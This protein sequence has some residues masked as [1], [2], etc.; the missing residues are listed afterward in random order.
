MSK[1]KSS[2]SDKVTSTPDGLKIWHQERVIFEVTERLC[3]LMEE[4]G[5][6][7]TELADLLGKTKGYITQILGGNANLTLRSLSDIYLALGHQFKVDDEPL[8]AEN[9]PRI[10]EMR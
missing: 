3:E 4:R 5:V 6:N 10:V 1:Q 9:V 7:R 8:I 2:L